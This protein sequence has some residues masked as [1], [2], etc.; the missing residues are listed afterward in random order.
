MKGRL[1]GSGY[2]LQGCGYEAHVALAGIAKE[3]EILKPDACSLMP[4]AKA[5]G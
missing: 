2:R 5:D 4:F 1:Q 3:P